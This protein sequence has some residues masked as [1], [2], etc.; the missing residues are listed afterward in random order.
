MILKGYALHKELICSCKDQ[1]L[2]LDCVKTTNTSKALIK[3]LMHALPDYFIQI[4][5]VSYISTCLK[6]ANS[7]IYLRDMV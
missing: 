4:T 5:G 6:T 1:A 2:V 7:F 3:N